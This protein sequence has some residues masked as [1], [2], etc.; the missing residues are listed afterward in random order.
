M[1]ESPRPSFIQSFL[2]LIFHDKALNLHEIVNKRHEELGPIYKERMGSFTLIFTNSPN[3][4]RKIFKLEG[5]TPK[6]FIPEVWM[7]YNDINKCSRGLLFMDGEEWLHFRR[8]M[9]RL[10]L[11]PN[12]ANAIINYACRETAITLTQK[13]GQYVNNYWIVDD[14]ENQ[15]YQWSIE[16][17]VAT[18][19]GSNWAQYKNSESYYVNIEKLSR[20]VHKIF[21]LSAKLSVIPINYA[22]MLR[23]LDWNE[24]V[25]T[26]NNVFQ[27][28]RDLIMGMKDLEGD[29]LISMMKKEGI[30][31]QDINRIVKDLIL[32]A[33]DT[34]AVSTVWA[35]YLLATHSDVQNEIAEKISGVKSSAIINDL[36]IKGI[37]KESL[38]LYPTAP[39]ITRILPVDA[40]IGN[41][42]VS[43][44][45]LIS[46]SLYSSGR[47]AKNFAHPNKFIPDRWI[48]N[49][50]SQYNK[51]F[52]AHASIPFA[53]GARS[54]VGRKL[55]EAQ[56]IH[57]LYELIK[58]FQIECT[59]ADK[60][61]MKLHLIAVP[62]EPIRLKLTPRNKV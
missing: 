31:E 33:G 53:M 58:N 60:I 41:Y 1:P 13:W 12:L 39:F 46:M 62:S 43:K 6:H 2:S 27:I 49:E 61:R 40:I 11:V 17:I 21:E 38:R 51:I 3:E 30:Q 23:F 8:I 7:R 59:N 26:F 16:A 54:C 24:L 48:R 20:S 35:L 57:L 29:G 47:D 9:N 4:Y 10:L 56:M 34:T 50:K 28:I 45:E 22:I 14:L 55:A 44:G 32:A 42:P 15:L 52:N 19:L 18:L 37:I 36:H 5:D 25:Q